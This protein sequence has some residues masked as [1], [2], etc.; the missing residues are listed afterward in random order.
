MC[1]HQTMRKFRFNKLIRDKIIKDMVR[2]GQSPVYRILD[3]DEYIE[4]LKKKILEEAAEIPLEDGDEITEKLADIEEI[5]DVL[6]KAL[7]VK[8]SQ[9]LAL[10][11]KKNL[12]RG[13]FKKKI[14]VDTVDAPE[15]SK[16]LEYY[17]KFPQKY[18]EIK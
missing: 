18:P 10:R 2:N 15:D 5:I 4:E 9:I 17:L 3:N 16:W 8:K 6:L 13:S 14:F 12:E 11:K 1:Y 7:K